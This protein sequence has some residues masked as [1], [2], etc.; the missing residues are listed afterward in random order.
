MADDR[1]VD[2]DIVAHDLAS[3]VFK[4][5]SASASSI[6]NSLTKVSK[7]IDR[8]NYAFRQYNSSMANFNSTLAGLTR[9]SGRAVYNFTKD[10][11]TEF[12]NLERQHAQ[13]MGAMQSNYD[14]TAESQRKFLDDSKKLQEQAI[15]LSKFGPTGKGS[16]YDSTQIS[17]VQTELVKS[18]ITADD[19]LKTGVINDVI[20][21]AGGNNLDLNEATDFAVN[22]GTQFGIKPADWGEMLDKVTKA[23]DISPIEVTDIMESMKYAGGISSGLN[24]SLDEVLGM[25]SV[26]GMAGLAGNMAGT[27]VQAMFSRI[28]AQQDLSDKQIGNAPT[29][30][31]GQLY[32]AFRDDVIKNGNLVDMVQVTDDLNEAFEVLNDEEQ[33]WFSK[34]M[35][36]LYQMKAAY[37]LAREGDDGQNLLEEAISQIENNSDGVLDYKYLA[38]LQTSYGNLESLKNAFTAVKQDFGSDLSPVTQEV[39]RQL[40]DWLVD[41]NNYHIDWSALE[42]AV[43]ESGDL[44]AQGY[45]R[46]LGDAVANIGYFGIDMAQVIGAIG[47]SR[48]T[49]LITGLTQLLNGDFGEAWDTFK[50]GIADANDAIDGLPEDL[51]DTAKACNNVITFFEILAGMDVATKIAQTITSLTTLVQN[52]LIKPILESIK[53][54]ISNNVLQSAVTNIAQVN[55]LN[56]ANA[57]VVNINGGL[58]NGLGTGLGSAAGGAAGAAGSAV[59]GYLFGKIASGPTIYGGGYGM[60]PVNPELPGNTIGTPLLEGETATSRWAFLNGLGATAGGLVI[61]KQIT[62]MAKDIFG[63]NTSST[64]ENYNMYVNG[65]SSDYND[66]GTFSWK[67]AYERLKYGYNLSDEANNKISPYGNIVSDLVQWAYDNGALDVNPILNTHKAN[68]T[69]SVSLMTSYIQGIADNW[70][71][72]E[73]AAGRTVTDEQYSEYIGKIIGIISDMTSTKKDKN[74]F[75]SNIGEIAYYGNPSKYNTITQD[76]LNRLTNYDKNTKKD[77]VSTVPPII[78]NPLTTRVSKLSDGILSMTGTSTV[79][80][81]KNNKNISA[82]LKSAIENSNLSL[83]TK[84]YTEKS[85]MLRPNFNV[86]VTVDNNGNIKSMTTSP[87]AWARTFSD[88]YSMQ[89][90]RFGN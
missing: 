48:S 85:I 88:S 75:E 50:Q 51:Q 65:S 23:A 77:G 81:T 31:V 21:F 73:L 46:E 52:L 9:V 18:G 38:M 34:K 20:K 17:S 64:A 58:I 89:S 16:L 14:K 78:K 29:K 19:I 33:A 25:I 63:F 6:F 61:G 83:K 13:T 69:T 8:A 62:E 72:R 86:R 74:S 76:I 87:S 53:K 59:G 49:S 80:I 1:R 3:A 57:T 2:I 55:A 12:A 39:S 28:L 44:I 54:S 10:S 60:S 32:N 22:L 11:I 24:R 40:H 27:G 67:Y 90:S 5:V 45:G 41:P 37:A 35:F 66:Y 47:P 79:D 84:M 68:D 30:Y 15:S 4:Q 56:V 7:G 71:Q 43:Q 70:L 36:G 42:S 82:E 26:M